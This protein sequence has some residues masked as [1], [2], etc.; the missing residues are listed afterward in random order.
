MNGIVVSQAC[1]HQQCDSLCPSPLPIFYFIYPQLNFMGNLTAALSPTFVAFLIHQ[2]LAAREPWLYQL[3]PA[4]LLYPCSQAQP[5]Q[6]TQP[7]Y[8]C[9][10]SFMLAALKLAFNGT[11]KSYSGA[12]VHSLL[13]CPRNYSISPLVSFLF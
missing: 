6:S 2:L 13:C 3:P 1:A 9:P 7:C 4:F 5:E 10:F 11:W 12:L 8:Q